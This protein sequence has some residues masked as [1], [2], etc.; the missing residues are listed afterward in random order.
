MDLTIV[1]RGCKRA[2]DTSSARLVSSCSDRATSGGRWASSTSVTESPEQNPSYQRILDAAKAL[3]IEQGFPATS[4][5]AIARRASVVRATVYNN[6]S[7][8]EAIVAEIMRRYIEGYVEIPQRL[9]EEARPEQTS[10][11]LV[12]DHDPQR[13]PVADR[14]CRA[15]T[16]DRSRPSTSR[17]PLGASSTL[18]PTRRCSA[19]S[20]RSTVAMPGAA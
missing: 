16:A 2:F 10:F 9:R 17:T 1:A 11:E 6:F 14:E 18:P 5:E 20:A 3:F 19:G 7:H 8:K 12:E 4:M 13:D 15:A